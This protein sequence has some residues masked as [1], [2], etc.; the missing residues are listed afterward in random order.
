MVLWFAMENKGPFTQAIAC[1]KH[2]W[3]YSQRENVVDLPSVLKT[4]TFPGIVDKG[5]SSLTKLM[6]YLKDINI[7]SAV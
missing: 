2:Q 4:I 1:N 7:R 6:G 5:L 3:T